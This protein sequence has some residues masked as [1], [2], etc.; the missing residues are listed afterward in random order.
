MGLAGPN[1]G[2]YRDGHG[3]HSH[4][5]Q[6]VVGRH[7]QTPAQV[8]RRTEIGPAKKDLGSQSGEQKSQHRTDAADPNHGFISLDTPTRHLAI[9]S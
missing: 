8:N 3:E 6:V 4:V 5:G 9:L 2:E 1:H 7:G